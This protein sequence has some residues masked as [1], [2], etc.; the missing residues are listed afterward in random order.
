MKMNS[1]PAL[2]LLQLPLHLL[3]CFTGDYSSY[4]LT[5]ATY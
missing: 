2:Q 3:V 4:K 1:I 5:L